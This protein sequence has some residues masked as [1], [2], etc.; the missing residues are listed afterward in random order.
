MYVDFLCQKT[1][2]I[3]TCMLTARFCRWPFW[4][5][6]HIGMYASDPYIVPQVCVWKKCV[7]NSCSHMIHT[8]I[9]GYWPNH[10]LRKFLPFYMLR[11]C[12]VVIN[13][14]LPPSGWWNYEVTWQESMLETMAFRMD[15]L[16]L[17]TCM[18]PAG[19]IRMFVPENTWHT[20]MYANGHLGGL[21][22]SA[23]ML[24]D[25]ILH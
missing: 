21:G 2:C 15:T 18:S 11:D 14:H 13:I 6:Q 1:L 17:M 12:N 25:P 19:F 3:P 22:M 7:S 4:S 20:H 9:T 10:F 23:F 16:C 8:W 5:T 24:T